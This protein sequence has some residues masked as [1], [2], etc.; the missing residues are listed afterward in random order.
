M[1]WTTPATWTQNQ[2]ITPALFNLH[3]RDNLNWLKTRPWSSVDVNFG[4]AS[5]NFER[6]TPTLSV[7]SVGGN[8]AMFFSGRVSHGFAAAVACAIDIAI[9]D[10]RVGDVTNGL[11]L[12]NTHTTIGN[13][14]L[15]T[16][17][18]I[19]TGS[20]TP[21]AGEHTYG[22]YIKAATAVSLTIVG[23][24]YVTELF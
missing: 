22:V 11:L 21:A 13:Y 1:A 17:F 9:D 20:T 24:L 3:L 23:T 5:A 18:Y 8:V 16:P 6:V 7:T 14:H 2:L 12:F 19:T 15:T 10:N 4:G